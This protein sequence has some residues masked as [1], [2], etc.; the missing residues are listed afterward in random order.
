MG[1]KATVHFRGKNVH[2]ILLTLN[3]MQ[4]SVSSRVAQWKRD[5]NGF[6]V[7]RLNH[8]ATTTLTCPIN[9]G[10]RI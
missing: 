8:P 3:I 7:H 5:P 1:W 6:L 2:F 9:T 4:L 10:E